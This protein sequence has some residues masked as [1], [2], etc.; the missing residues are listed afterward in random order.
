MRL[1]QQQS[2]SEAVGSLICS[3]DDIDQLLR[4][5]AVIKELR[6][7]LSDPVELAKQPGAIY[8]LHAILNT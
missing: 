3:A 7:Q 6:S 5:E 4:R 2:V 1:V 8:R